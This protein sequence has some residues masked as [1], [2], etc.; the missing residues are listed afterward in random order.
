MGIERLRRLARPIV[1]GSH[2]VD[3]IVNLANLAG[4]M[5]SFLTTEQRYY[6][7]EH[8]RTVGDHAEHAGAI[9][10]VAP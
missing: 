9:D 10:E 5:A 4:L 7:A 6:I 3:A 2:P 8:L 1:N